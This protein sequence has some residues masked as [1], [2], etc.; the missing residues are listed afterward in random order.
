MPLGTNCSWYSYICFTVLPNLVALGVAL[1]SSFL[2]LHSY[3]NLWYKYL[4]TIIPNRHSLSQREASRL[5]TQ[6]SRRDSHSALYAQRSTLYDTPSDKGGYITFNRH[7]GC[8]PV[9][10]FEIEHP[11][12]IIVL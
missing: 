4:H 11:L 5:T 7:Y 1:S 9:L 12:I 8:Q 6:N 10:S 2:L 3:H